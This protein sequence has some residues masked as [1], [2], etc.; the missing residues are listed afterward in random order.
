MGQ[1]GEYVCVT[2]FKFL[3]ALLRLYSVSTFMQNNEQFFSL[4]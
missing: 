2:M 1:I 4:F 3:T